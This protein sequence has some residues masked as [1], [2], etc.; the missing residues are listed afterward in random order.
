MAKIRIFEV[1][2]L[3]QCKG[4]Y[5]GEH[6]IYV[7]GRGCTIYIIHKD[8]IS[9]KFIVPQSIVNFFV[10]SNNIYIGTISKNYISYSLSGTK[11][12]CIH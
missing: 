7:S 4:I 11:V 2:F 5:R 12:F 3:I 6:K 1:P 8:S 10:S 9:N